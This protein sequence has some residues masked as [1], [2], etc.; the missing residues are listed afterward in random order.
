[1]ILELIDPVAVL[2]L[3]MAAVG[4]LVALAY[5]KSDRR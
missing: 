2:F 1:M 3:L 4:L 5:G